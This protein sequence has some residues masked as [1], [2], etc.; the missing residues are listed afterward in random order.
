MK[1][2]SVFKKF[3]SAIAIAFTSVIVMVGI[4]ITAHAASTVTFDIS[5]GPVNITDSTYSGYNSAGTAINGSSSDVSFVITGATTTNTVTVSGTQDITLSNCSI[6]VSSMSSVCAFEI[7]NDNTG[8]VN[9]TLVGEN[10]LKSGYNRAGLEKNVSASCGTL[11]ILGTGKLAATG[12]DHGA[13]IGGGRECSTSKITISGGNVTATGGSHAAGIG[14]GNEG[15]G[16]NIT[17]TGGRVTANGGEYGAGI[18]GGGGD[19][20][21]RSNLGIGQSITISGGTVTA[22]G[23]G[24]GTGNGGAGIGGGFGSN[25]LDIVIRGGTV[26]AYG[27]DGSAGIGNGN[28]GTFHALNPCIYITGGDIKAYGGENGAGIGAGGGGDRDP[29]SCGCFYGIRI[30]GGTIYAEGGTWVDGITRPHGAAGIG[31]SYMGKIVENISIEGGTITA[32]GAANAAGIGGGDTGDC[33][34]VIIIGGSVKATAG[35]GCTNNIGSGTDSTVVTSITNRT[36]PVYLNTISN[37]NS[38]PVYIDGVSYTPVNHKAVDHADTNLYVYLTDT[39]HTIQLKTTSSF[40]SASVIKTYGDAAFS[41]GFTTDSNGTVSYSSS[42]TS[43]ATVA[44]NGTV[45]IKGAGSTTITASIPATSSYTADRKI[46]TLA[47]NKATPTLSGV[48]ASAITYGQTLASSTI[49]GTAKVGTTTIAGSFTWKTSST[50]PNAGT[51]VHE[52]VFTPT[53]TT[54]YAVV[55]GT[56]SVSVAKADPTITASSVQ[57]ITYGQKLSE[58]GIS[59]SATGVDDVILTGTWEYQTPNAIPQVSDSGRTKYTIVFTPSDTNY[60]SKTVATMVQ[61]SPA[62]LVVTPEIKASIAASQITYGDTLA[63]STISGTTPIGVNGQNVAGQYVWED[64]TIAP[65]VFDSN[66]TKYNVVFKPTDNLNYTEAS[67]LQAT[68]TVVKATPII[69]PEMK[70]T[71]SATTITYNQTLDDS[72]LSGTTPISGH[73]EWVDNT[74]APSVADSGVTEYAVRFIPDD[75]ANNNTV[76]GITCKLTVNKATP[77]VNSSVLATL[78]ASDITY[79]DSLADSSITGDLPVNSKGDNVAGDYAWADSSIQ[80]IVHDSESHPYMVIFTPVDTDNYTTATFTLT[81]KVN[82]ATPVVT[83]WATATDV[84]YGHASNTAVLARGS[85]SVPGTFRITNGTTVANVGTYTY[86]CDFVPTDSANYNSVAGS[87][88]VTV[89]AQIPNAQVTNVSNLVYEHTLGDSTISGTVTDRVSNEVL[90][91][92]WRWLTPEEVP[93]VN[94]SATYSVEWT[95]NSSNYTSVVLTDIAQPVVAKN[96]T[97]AITSPTASDII[98]GQFV[99]DSTLTGGSGSV[100]GTFSWDSSYNG[101]K[102]NAGTD[103]YTVV[104]TPSDINNY[105]TSTTTVQLTTNKATP[106]LS[107]AGLSASAIKF[108]QSLAESE[109]TWNDDMQ[110]SGTF[111][112]SD[113]SIKPAVTGTEGAPTSYPVIFYPD[114]SD[115]YTTKEIDCTITVNKG[116]LPNAPIS[117]TISSLIGNSGSYSFGTVVTQAGAVVSLSSVDNPEYFSSVPQITSDGSKFEYTVKRSKSLADK[118]TIVHFIVTCRDYED[119]DLNITININDCDH[120]GKTTSVINHVDATCTSNGYTGDTICDWCETVIRTGTEITALGHTEE[121]RNAREATCVAKGYTGDT[122]CSVCGALLS[123]GT[124]IPMKNHTMDEGTVVVEP[125]FNT[126][127]IKE[128]HCTACNKLL[129]SEVLNEYDNSDTHVDNKGNVITEYPDRTV[130]ESPDGTKTI[131]YTSGIK[132]ITSENG[133]YRVEF[134]DGTTIQRKD[135]TVS[136]LIPGI[137]DELTVLG[138]EPLIINSDDGSRTVINPDGSYHVYY[139]D[140]TQKVVNIDGTIEIISSYD[141]KKVI[142]P[143]G[144]TD[145]ILSDGTIVTTNGD[146]TTSTISYPNG[147]TKIEVTGGATFIIYPDG[148]TRVE[149]NGE[150]TITEADGTTLYVGPD[151]ATRDDSSIVYVDEAGNKRVEKPDGTILEISVDGVTTTTH[152]DGSKEVTKL[153]GTKTY[154]NPDNTSYVINQDGSKVYKDKDGNDVTELP[155]GTTIIEK[156]DGTTITKLPNGV[157]TE[158]SPDGTSTKTL[159]DGTIIIT[160]PDGTVIT[161]KPDGTVITS[162]PDGTRLTKKPDG[163]E[164]TTRPDGTSVTTSADGTITETSPG[165]TVTIR[166]PDKTVVVKRSDGVVITTRPDGVIEIKQDDITTTIETNKIATT[167]VPGGISVIAR[168]GEPIE[169]TGGTVTPE[170]AHTATLDDGTRVVVYP[171][172]TIAI[173]KPDGTYTVYAPGGSIIKSDGN[174]DKVVISPDGTM[175]IT[176]PNGDTITYSPNGTKIEKTGDT[177]TTTTPEGTVIKVS[178]DSEVI[179]LPDGTEVIDGVVHLGGLIGSV[180]SIGADSVTGDR[181]TY[182]LDGTLIEG[183]GSTSKVKLVTSNESTEVDAYKTLYYVAGLYDYVTY[184]RPL[185]DNMSQTTFASGLDD[186]VIRGVDAGVGELKLY[187]N[188]DLAIIIYGGSEVLLRPDGT[189]TITDKDGTQTT[190]GDSIKVKEPNGNVVTVENGNTTVKDPSGNTTTSE[191]GKTTVTTDK[192]NVTVSDN[193]ISIGGQIIVV[194]TETVSAPVISPNGGSF[195]G[196]K[197]VTIT[198]ATEGVTIYYTVDGSD[199][200]TSSTKYTGALEIKST[201][202]V[203]AIA[204]KT[205]MIDSKVTSAEF[206]KRYGSIGGGGGGSSRPSTPT[207]PSNPTIGGVSKSWTT[208]ASD[209]SKLKPGDT[210]T[211]GLSGGSV[212]PSD[213]IKAIADNKVKATFVVNSVFK[214]VVDGSKITKPSSVDLTFVTISSIK[215]SGLRGTVGTQ[216]RING[217][218]MPTSLEISFKAT[219][220]GK[221]A[222]LYR[223]VNGKFVFV[224]C[225]KIGADGKV[226]IPNV[227]EKGDYIV[228]LDKLSGVLGDMTNDGILNAMDASAILKDIV[229]LEK[230]ANPLMADFNGDGYMNAMDASAILKRIVG[231]A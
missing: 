55:T 7:E 63:N 142:H 163:T 229:G 182:T 13:G 67:G 185:S 73:Y 94:G 65:E 167:T 42:N 74:I 146:G 195:T 72:Q 160:K 24:S 122:Y 33:S 217:T 158:V 17:I 48:S 83:T 127:G 44:S 169:I 71:I 186:Y 95:P 153:D 86:D 60:N 231:L 64:S 188:G 93:V 77:D 8:N 197:K 81:L 208:V 28:L 11:T 166:Y 54:N 125:T 87:V 205:G 78:S 145:K 14:G 156:P 144:D 43:V 189:S 226:I 128:Y 141:N 215:P 70:A 118:S 35:S 131:E 99:T 113:S 61:V 102:P 201:T 89:V 140:G 57:G 216:F 132:V 124:N 112:W 199:P 135:D 192:D 221:F 110:I 58:T 117:D 220:A 96:D 178:T 204:V 37:P 175:V 151:Q 152:P 168:P 59:G 176:K 196:S 27:G 155:N 209:I 150:I 68:V 119:F 148:S 111:T 104:F 184:A 191:N 147:T 88:V 50:A 30:T 180:N 98:Y 56:T 26:T 177:T 49:T 69:T 16:R 181:F 21:G 25:C 84:T 206:T 12:G 22:T 123:N 114:D 133:D 210:V 39:T 75:T 183:E 6:D 2:S 108:G 172:G 106:S 218:G 170:G 212:V 174:N 165:G 52:Y 15:K 154:T 41:A 45:T 130:I 187:R 1:L 34:N 100:P 82:K 53:D 66:N 76:E 23:G 202:T 32:V 161:K 121:T 29:G 109:L 5:K 159:V 4:P 129:K 46:M 171:D 79:G 223:V 207:E 40:S 157:T 97:N 139:P 230:G 225:A 149:Q 224:S 20:F 134:P 105:N 219:H 62:T 198:C 194:P 3:A 9:V 47:V 51:L 90:T 116:E 227:S 190:I 107:D 143:N 162:Y 136:V 126:Q 80:P 19:N 91:G 179:T 213:V 200:T 193:G 10:I 36:S 103:T 92:T 228:M 222:N 138:D 173:V 164:F 18:G 38:K 31:G 214:W 101:L 115:N 137:L 85:A 211:I 120:V 203:K